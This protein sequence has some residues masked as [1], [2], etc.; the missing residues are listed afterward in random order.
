MLQWASCTRYQEIKA[1]ILTP[2]SRKGIF[3][4]A[5][6]RLKSSTTRITLDSE[7]ITSIECLESEMGRAGGLSIG[8]NV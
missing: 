4:M 1:S 3:E 5:I 2:K 8:T 7:S 6:F